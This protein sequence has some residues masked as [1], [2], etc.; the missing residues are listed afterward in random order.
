MKFVSTATFAL[1]RVLWPT[2]PSSAIATIYCRHFRV[3]ILGDTLACADADYKN[4][5]HRPGKYVSYQATSATSPNRLSSADLARTNALTSR[6][7]VS[8][9]RRVFVFARCILKHHLL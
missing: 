7:S 8:S 4:P 1:R 3:Q 5:T 2:V 6:V 9:H